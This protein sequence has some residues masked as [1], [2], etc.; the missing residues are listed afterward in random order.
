MIF[1]TN[2][3][4]SK[5]ESKK[6]EHKQ[7]KPVYVQLFSYYSPLSFRSFSILFSSLFILSFRFFIDNI[8]II[9]AVGMASKRININN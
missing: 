2:L 7:N 4:L 1:V 5:P 9:N 8:K 6:A 3:P